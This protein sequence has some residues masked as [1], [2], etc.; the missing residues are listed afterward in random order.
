[1]CAHGCCFSVRISII[2]RYI[3]IGETLFGSLSIQR[4]R[5]ARCQ[6]ESLR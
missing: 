6:S 1:M 4:K 3:H 2:S 5:M